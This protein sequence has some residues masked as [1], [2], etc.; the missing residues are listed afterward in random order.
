MNIFEINAC[1]QDPLSVFA[2][3]YDEAVGIFI[4]YW[5]THF[6]PA[7]LPDI[8]IK[9]RHPSWPGLDVTLLAEALDRGVAGVGR[10]DPA[11]GWEILAPDHIREEVA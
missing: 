11:G 6:D 4:I 2:Q 7:D 10:F 3:T 9:R 5:A 1:G 8:E